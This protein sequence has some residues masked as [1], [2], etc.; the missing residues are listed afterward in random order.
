MK[1][2]NPE[3]LEEMISIG[4]KMMICDSIEDEPELLR[5]I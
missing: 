1:I 4:I 2:N 3:L 5:E